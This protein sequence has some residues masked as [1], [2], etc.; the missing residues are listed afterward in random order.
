MKN[1]NKFL[2]ALALGSFMASCAEQDI[3]NFYVEKPESIAN[4]EKLLEYGNIKDYVDRAKYPNFKIACALGAADYNAKGI[5]YRVANAN[6]DEIT[7]GN[8]MKYASVVDD[9]G[10]MDFSTIDEL[11]TNAVDAGLSVYGHTLAWHA[12]QNTTYLKSCIADVKIP[13]E[14][15][16]DYDIV[17]ADF[18]DGETPFSGSVGVTPEIIN[19][20]FTANCTKAR[21][22]FYLAQGLALT[23][24]QKYEAIIK[25][26]CTNKD[27]SM[28]LCLCVS[29]Y[30]VDAEGCTTLPLTADWEEFKVEF[31]PSTDNGYI[32]VDMGRTTGNL[33]F[34]FV[35]IGHYTPDTRSMTAAEKADTLSKEM[36]RWVDAMMEACDSRVQAWDMIN[37]AISG[38]D[39]DGDGWYDL[40]SAATGGSASDFFWQDYL[41]PE[42]YGVIVE[43]AAREAY[44]KHG[45]NAADLKLFVNDYNLESDWDDNMKLKSMIHWIKVWESNGTTKIDGVSSQMHISYYENKVTMASKAKHMVNMLHLMANTGKLV[46]IS[47]LD[48]GYVDIN[49]N[50]LATADLTTEQHQNMANYYQFIIQMYLKIV[51]IA[52]QYSICQWCLTDADKSSGWRANTPVGLW[53]L[54]WNRKLTFAA[55]CEALTRPIGESED[56]FQFLSDNG[57]THYIY[58]PATEKE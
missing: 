22:Q 54:N 34:E 31:T 20:I 23:P 50:D 57:M 12:Q 7:L 39:S 53:D 15:V 10:N 48:M 47:E 24:G 40:Q 37:E 8:A 33:E 29:K 19:G 38:G 4:N 16:E 14:R 1:Y 36:Y 44:A 58:T 25:A 17:Y 3:E 5:V 2:V 9:E 27:I 43:K 6:F 42:N 49:G 35:N 21:S 11:L 51:P 56:F 30:T 32:F 13:T 41:G 46:R 45:G 26:R 55:Y 28:P 18:G 52:Q